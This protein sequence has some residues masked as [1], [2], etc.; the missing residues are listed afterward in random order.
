MN[1]PRKLRALVPV[2]TLALLILALL[3]PSA[4][5]SNIPPFTSTSQYKA[6]TQ[7]VE[8]LH[9]VSSTPVTAARKATYENQL[10]NK[11]EAAVNKSTA[12]F[13]RAKKA[14]KAEAQRAFK[15]GAR[16]IRSTEAGELAALRRVYD[17]RMDQAAA[18]H[19]AELGRVEDA[20]DGR[21]ASLRKQLKSLRKQKANAESALRKAEIQ[22]AIE[23]RTERVK[24]DRKLLQEEIVDLKAG[25]RREKASIRAAK[26][27]A[28]RVVQQSDDQA[29]ATLRSHN[30]RI[31]N[32]RVGTL[33]NRRAN[34]VGSLEAKLNAGR[35]A[36]ARMPLV[37]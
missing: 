20:F 26:A 31:Y 22:A 27:S 7:F 28:T 17:T 21:T 33:Q 14:A 6:L 13:N 9:G 11:H 30:N 19:E 25:Y 18:R 5:A 37:G 16:T 29:I 32:T 23:R 34:Q 10:E 15:A 36:I 12:L 35:A 3:A 24:G 4:G 2:T 8:K 1:S